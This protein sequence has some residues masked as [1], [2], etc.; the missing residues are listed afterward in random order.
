MFDDAAHVAL[1]VTHDAAVAG[2]VRQHLGQYRCARSARGQQALQRVRLHQRHIAIQHQGH[3]VLAIAF[4]QQQRHRL[5]HGVAGALLR[6]LQHEVQIGLAVERLFD[7]V[8]AMAHH[9]DDARRLQLARAVQHVGQ[10]GLARQ[11]VQH[12]G[13]VGLHAF[14]Q[15][16]GKDHYIKHKFQERLGRSSGLA[17][18]SRV[19]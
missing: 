10:H 8:G 3:V 15:S 1:G 17:A 14:A 2:G 6:L 12:F 7:A 5:L 19:D 4:Q 16:G 9:D 11:R 18:V 13:K